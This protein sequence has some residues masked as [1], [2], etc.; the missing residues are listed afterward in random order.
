MCV[1]RP[2][3]AETAAGVLTRTLTKYLFR[4]TLGLTM[5][6]H[7]ERRLLT[8]YLVGRSVLHIT[9]SDDDDHKSR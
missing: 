1:G 3:R 7:I 5:V 2:R 9:W 8:R 6:N 4:R